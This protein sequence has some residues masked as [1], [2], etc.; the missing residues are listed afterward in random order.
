MGRRLQSV[1]IFVGLCL[2][3]FSLAAQAQSQSCSVPAP[4]T[5]SKE[6][7][8]FNE[9]Q[10]GWLGDLIANQI[11]RGFKIVPDPENGYLK[12]IADRVLAQLPPSGT[13]YRFTIIDLPDNDSF[14]IPGGRIYLSRRIVSLIRNED[15]L[16]GL[17]GH[18]IGHII[19]RQQAIA[20]TR[21]F[22]E[23]LGISRLGDHQDVINQWNRFLNLIATK[24][25]KHSEK[26]EEA[27]Q[28]VA[29]RIA[30]Y[31]MTRAGYQPQY[32]M[33]FFDR[34]A[35]TH[36]NKGNVWTDL[37]GRT[38]ADSRRLRE[39][40]KNAAPLPAE[41]IAMP[42]TA[43]PQRFAAWQKKVI[44][45]EFANIEEA[46]PGLISRQALK[47]AL[48]SDLRQLTYSEDGKY[49]LAQDDS[50]I[51]ILTA[52]PVTL[53]AQIEAPDTFAAW[54]SPDLKAVVSYDKEL[55]VQTW[56]IATGRRLSIHQISTSAHCGQVALS[57]S[58]ETLACLDHQ[59]H[60]QLFNVSDSRVLSS[61]H[62]LK[63]PSSWPLLAAFLAA[64]E[65]GEPF[66]LFSM[67]FSPDDR[68][69]VAGN[70]EGWF[71]FDLKSSSEVSL[72]GK[73][74][75]LLSN[76]FC[77]TAGEEIA[78]ISHHNRTAEIVRAR[79]PSGET[80]KTIPA[81]QNG[82]L[83][84]AP[85]GKHYLLRNGF[86]AQ[87]AVVDSTTGDIPVM[88]KKPA[89]SVYGDVFAGETAGGEIGVYGVADKK[90]QSG[91]DLPTGALYRPEAAA[92]STNARWFALSEKTR[93]AVWD[94][95][96]GER[97]MLSRG[98]DGAYFDQQQLFACFPKHDKEAAAVFRFDPGTRKM[99]NA[100]N[101]F[102]PEH[103]PGQ[104]FVPDPHYQQIGDVLIKT[105]WIKE[106]ISGHW[107][108]EV[109]DVRDNHK[110]WERKLHNRVPR[111]A[112]AGNTLTLL[113]GFYPDMKAEAE[114]DPSLAAK[115]DALGDEK[116]KAASYI[117]EVLGA[118]SGKEIGK[119]LVDTGNLSFAIAYANTVGDNVVVSDSDHRTL[120]YSLK[121]AELKGTIFGA[122]RAVA[123]DGRRM[124]VEDGKG[125]VDLI[126]VPEMRPL[127]HY[128]FPSGIAVAGFSADG[129]KAV[130][131]DAKQTVYKL[132]VEV[133]KVEALQ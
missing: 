56:E 40:A 87:V 66:E 29:D 6:P 129:E 20:L 11:E 112:K 77:F 35:Q 22:Q 18:E 30:L 4:L 85:D 102:M 116:R 104:I 17:L 31:A 36:G 75:Q 84:F 23:I 125:K 57:H 117:V 7:N 110:L 3:W 98:F 124:L 86:N 114:S 74:K 26:R 45:S 47:P 53:L 42:S 131:I 118:A 43:D 51:Y 61:G 64:V 127:A 115:L 16:A 100:F 58:G 49:L 78:T 107:L 119:L 50:T 60:L 99:E 103:L 121:T 65:A 91:I 76:D 63:P 128:Q 108:M 113:V 41:C 39:L 111:M 94:L 25:L 92:L 68:Y 13:H 130:V 69:F 24:K 27:E 5:I 34:L 96:T 81:K 46:L 1:F 82:I 90:Y 73:L 105:T 38:S 80:V 19:A 101:L 44:G 89:F 132:K 93:G 97:L 133:P 59:L 32:F 54:F 126:S 33:D 79:F 10:E 37:F 21:D 71:A 8:I 67:Q 52:A 28:L 106:K 83:S 95:D 62:K 12:T 88:Y 9:Q 55:R 48:R 123:S 14:G 122:P 72:S 120:F 2:A 70:N 109:Y 15:E